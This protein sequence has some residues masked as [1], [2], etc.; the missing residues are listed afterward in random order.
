MAQQLKTRTDL[1][2]PLSL[3]LSS[4]HPHGDLQVTAHE[5][6]PEDLTSSSDLYTHTGTDVLYMH[7]CRHSIHA[8]K[9]HQKEKLNRTDSYYITFCVRCVTCMCVHK[10][11][12]FV[13]ALYFRGFSLLPLHG[14]QGLNMDLEAWL[15]A[16]LPAVTSISLAQPYSL[17]LDLT[18]AWNSQI[19][20][21][22]LARAPGGVCLSPP[23]LKG[24]ARTDQHS[25]LSRVGSGNQT[26]ILM[27]AL[28]HYRH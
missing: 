13:V 25:G 3:R 16:P 6:V 24:M 27:L 19:K 15:Q 4:Q 20:L 5:S 2:G 14:F 7:T 8:H 11:I 9:I 17:R 28:W 1:L 21:D 26:Q 18:L 10:H 22:W 23:P 12:F